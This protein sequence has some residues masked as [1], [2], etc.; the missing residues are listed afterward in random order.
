MGFHPLDW[1]VILVIGL[2]IFGPKAVQS[3]ARNAGK[4]VSQAK[5]AKDKLLA[6]LPMEE[7]NQ[8]RDNISRIPMSP[9][10]A[11]QMLLTPEQEQVRKQEAQK[12]Q[13]AAQTT[14]EI[15]AEAKPATQ[16]AETPSPSPAE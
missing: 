3:M 10:Q 5:V 6:E 15:A 13:A 12:A 4:S 2:L 7:L 8:V 11:V 14:P 9:Q 1:A 16:K